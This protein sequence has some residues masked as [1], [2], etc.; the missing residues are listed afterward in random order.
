MRDCIN[1]EHKVRKF[2]SE[3]G[4][5]GPF[6]S[7]ENLWLKYKLCPLKS[8]F[9]LFVFDLDKVCSMDILCNHSKILISKLERL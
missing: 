6:V 7:N 9:V 1:N 5:I 4:E 2:L 8:C 3:Y